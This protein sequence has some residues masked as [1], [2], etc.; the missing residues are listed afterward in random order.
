MGCGYLLRMLPLSG[1]LGALT[2]VILMLLKP[3]ALIYG[4]AKLWQKAEP[5]VAPRIPP[6]AP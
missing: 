6:K 1:I 3:V 4:A 2:R 5:F